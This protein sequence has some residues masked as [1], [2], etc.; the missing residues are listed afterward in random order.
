VSDYPD[1]T[2]T[3]VLKGIYD[4]KPKALAVDF[5]GNMVAM[6][7]GQFNNLPKNVELDTDGNIQVNLF[8]QELSQI[9][10][11]YKFGAPDYVTDSVEV[12]EL[13]TELLFETLSRGQIYASVI[14]VAGALASADKLTVTMDGEVISN[15][16]IQTLY[17]YRSF[18]GTNLPVG[19]LRYSVSPAYYVLLLTP[20][21]TFESQYKVQYS[22]GAVPMNGSVTVTYHIYY[23]TI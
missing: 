8:A 22:H 12:N 10:N 1:F 3:A 11:R 13:A 7:K 4:E 23:T 16:T 14:N 2:I 19:I 5:F 9:V 17:E 20:G 18:A 15:V 21:Y 6:L